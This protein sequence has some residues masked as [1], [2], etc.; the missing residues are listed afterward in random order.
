MPTKT[1]VFAASAAN[2]VLGSILKRYSTHLANRGRFQVSEQVLWLTVSQRRSELVR[3]RLAEMVEHAVIE[4]NVFTFANFSKELVAESSVPSKGITKLQK[5]YL[6]RRIL[7]EKTEKEEISYYSRI[8][9]T[10]GLLDLVSEKIAELK[11][12]DIWAEDFSAH[13]QTP[14]DRDLASIYSAYQRSLHRGNLYDAEGSFWLARKAISEEKSTSLPQFRMVV[15]DGFSDF[16]TAQYDI[17]R[18]LSRHSKEFLLSLTLGSFANSSIDGEDGREFLF[19]KP[20]STLAKIKQILPGIEI[21]KEAESNA[22]PQSLK[23]LRAN[24][25]RSKPEDYENT[26][27]AVSIVAASGEQAEIN[28]LAQRIKEMLL[29]KQARPN[30]ILVVFPNLHS[31]SQKIDQTFTDFGIPF[32]MAKRPT[33]FSSALVRTL[34]EM[35]SLHQEDWPYRKLINLISNR[36]IGFFDDFE[37]SGSSPELRVKLE[38]CLRTAQLPSGKKDLLRQL[39]RWAKVAESVGESEGL[40]NLMNDASES[41]AKLLDF[42]AKL[43]SLPVRSLLN[44]WIQKTDDLLE[45]LGIINSS[46]N[47]KPFTNWLQLKKNLLAIQNVQDWTQKTQTINI[48]EYISLIALASRN[49]PLSPE[50]DSVGKVQILEASSARHLGA[51][52]VFLAGL[53]EQAFSGQFD[54]DSKEQSSDLKQQQHEGMFL[55]YEL[56]SCATECLTLSYP[57]FD[58]K[59]Q[60]L[61]P[62]PL[63]TELRKCFGQKVVPTVSMRLGENASALRSPLSKSELR[64]QSVQRLLEGDMALLAGLATSP[65]VSHVGGAILDAMHVIDIRADRDEFSEFEG[66]VQDESTKAALAKRYDTNHIWSPSQLESYATC[67]YRFFVEQIL[68]IEALSDL[69]IRSNAARRGSLLHQVLANVHEEL[70]QIKG[71][72]DSVD[73]LVERFSSSLAKAIE[74]A[75]LSGLDE[76]LREIERREIENWAQD[77]SQQENDYRQHW[78]DLDQPMQPKHFEVRFGPKARADRQT[79]ESDSS[80]VIPFELDLGSEQIR[81]TGQID[82]ID[83]GR[84]GGVTVFNIIDYKSGKKQMKLDL[85]KVRSGHQLQLPLYTLA[86][87]KYLFADEDARALS[88]GY[89]NVRSNG[90]E[91]NRKKIGFSVREIAEQTLTTTPEWEE[92][93]PV[94][95]ER[96]QQIIRG[97]RS[98]MFPV[99]NDD[100]NCTASCSCNTMCRIAQIRSLEKHWGVG[101]AADAE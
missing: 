55:F 77:Y 27:D 78:N 31:A 48:T 86:A 11:R 67:P 73:E 61:S 85:K 82:R 25:F 6:L 33:L 75:P 37:E 101:E 35:L 80:T 1:I 92:L 24:L 53:T 79:L 63:L 62:S 93:L 84:V 38:L 95:Q 50:G 29:S 44:E 69:A 88:A 17:L 2:A 54:R 7:D 97:V 19:S 49:T 5:L 28:D 22:I 91:K 23:H 68:G 4:P 76:S 42:S 16:T 94:M 89:W 51:K 10:P 81:L 90:F 66:M 83:V 87:E 12:S 30:E 99:Y 9:D 45:T 57:A 26:I 60:S 14:A 3:T 70:L 18:V 36:L 64:Q 39:E 46:L 41:L 72:S 96:I 58:E 13:A 98:G 20:L 56:M 34:I 71:T 74:S 65:G 21:D 32:D 8:A 43:E 52:H 47:T 40:P 15:I 100:K 59:G